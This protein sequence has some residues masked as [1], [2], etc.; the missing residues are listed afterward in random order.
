MPEA[1]HPG[2]SNRNFTKTPNIHNI[3]IPRW[4]KA[5]ALELLN[6]QDHFILWHTID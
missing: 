4:T 3:Q 6:P 2:P 1:E 5:A